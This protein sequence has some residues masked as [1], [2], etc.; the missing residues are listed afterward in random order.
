MMYHL[1]TITTDRQTHRRQYDVNSRSYLECK[2]QQLM[3]T[4]QP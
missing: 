1:A 2:D 3:A 4:A